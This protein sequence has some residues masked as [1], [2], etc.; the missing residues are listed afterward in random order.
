MKLLD[1]I[2]SINSAKELSSGHILSWSY[3][4]FQLWNPSGEPIA[5]SSVE[6]LEDMMELSSG[7]IL[8]KSSNELRLWDA[9]GK[10]SGKTMPHQGLTGVKELPDGRILSWAADNSLGLW[11]AN[12]EALSRHI[13][14]FGKPLL[15]TS[16]LMVLSR[17]QLVKLG[18]VGAPL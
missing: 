9:D 8:S 18:G 16:S 7:R 15:V 13:L 5:E 4:K 10:A 3:R 6:H 2:V 11:D 14:W 12:G 1:G 17:T